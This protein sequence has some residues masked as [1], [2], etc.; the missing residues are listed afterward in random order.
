MEINDGG[1]AAREF[2][3]EGE[4]D[5]AESSQESDEDE[6]VSSA[7][8]SQDEE[9][10]TDG[11]QEASQSEFEHSEATPSNTPQKR[12]APV[13]KN[14]KRSV[15]AQLES[16]SSTLEV[17]RDFFLHQMSSNKEVPVARREGNNRGKSS[18]QTID[19]PS[20]MTIYNN[21]LEKIA[22]DEEMVDPEIVFKVNKVDK[23]RNSSSSEDRIDTS[24]E[25]MDVEDPPNEMLNDRFI[26]DCEREAKRRHSEEAG[27]RADNIR[28][29]VEVVRQV[30][31]GVARVH[32]IPGNDLPMFDGNVSSNQMR[33][34]GNG[35]Q[36][37]AVWD[38]NYISIGSNVDN[39]TKDKIT[40][41][42][43]VDLE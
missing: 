8:E 43:Y 42:E 2:E 28:R 37:S 9:N 21:A 31:A 14:R 10:N 7:E 23:Q 29:S 40:R 5:M 32:N 24:D 34:K 26:A 16:M 22:P 4:Q 35:Q 18:E 33:D 20:V 17:M 1:A 12:K 6:P 30:E 3:S 13:K 19:S 25:L 11:E 27:H 38:E 36:L 39:Q 41:G 15:E